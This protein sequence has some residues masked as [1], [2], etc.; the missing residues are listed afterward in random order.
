MFCE[1]VKKAN[2]ELYEGRPTADPYIFFNEQLNLIGY[3]INIWLQK[4]VFY[5][6]GSE[7]DCHCESQEL[8]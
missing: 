4:V 2:T 3:T 1:M 7:C 8:F 6:R 5:C